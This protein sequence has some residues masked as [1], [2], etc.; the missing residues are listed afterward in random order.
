[1]TEAKPTPRPAATLLLLRDTGSAPEVFMLQRTSKAAFLPGAFVFPGGALDPDDSSERAARRVRGLDDAQAS[2]RLGL[3]SGG[4][5]YWVA[6]ARECFE[7][8]GILLLSR[9]SH[10]AVSAENPGTIESILRHLTA[11]PRSPH[12]PRP[13][14]LQPLDHRAGALAARRPGSSS[15]RARRPG[16]LARRVRRCTTCDAAAGRVGATP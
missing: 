7:E 11:K 4:L 14:L 16:R 9:G 12:L 1:V 6:A 5:A 13:R 10:S 15:P 2:A 8:S 3:A